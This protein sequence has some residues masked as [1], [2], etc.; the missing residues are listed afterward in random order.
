MSEYL[1]TSYALFIL[2]KSSTYFKYRDLLTQESN[3]TW[4]IVFLGMCGCFAFFFITITASIICF[5]RRIVNPIE[6][7][8]SYTAQLKEKEDVDSKKALIDDVKK[9]P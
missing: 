8:K 1:G 2:V 9:S 3:Q 4:Y 6:A 5:S 7:L